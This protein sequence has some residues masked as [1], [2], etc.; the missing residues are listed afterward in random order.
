MEPSERRK[1]PRL[2]Q[3]GRVVGRATVMA[4][5]RVVSL[6]EEGASLETSLPMALGSPCDLSLRLGDGSLDLKARVRSTSS[7]A[8]D[9]AGPFEVRVAFESLDEADRAML[10]FFLSSRGAS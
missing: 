6:S 10:R 1:H 8:G 2:P 3:G 5:F 7:L 9:E 4:D